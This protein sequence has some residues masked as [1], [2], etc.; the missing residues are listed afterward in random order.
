MIMALLHDDTVPSVQLQ[1]HLAGKGVGTGSNLV[2]WGKV[3]KVFMKAEKM[4]MLNRNGTCHI[5]SG[6]IELKNECLIIIESWVELLV[7]AKSLSG[8][9]QLR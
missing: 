8:R 2:S 6:D 3:I 5:L 4:E 9:N 1:L 7:E